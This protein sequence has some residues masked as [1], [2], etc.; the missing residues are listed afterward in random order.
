MKYEAWKEADW[1]NGNGQEIR[2][3]K[4]SLLNTLQH[5][6]ESDK[7]KQ[8]AS[9]SVYLIDKDGSKRLRSAL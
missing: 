3:W 5:L 9:N 8:Q 4:S 1:I 6:N 2:N 7:A